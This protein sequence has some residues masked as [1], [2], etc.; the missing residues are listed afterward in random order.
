VFTA[1][2]GLSTYMKQTRFFLKGLIKRRRL[3]S[4]PKQMTVLFRTRMQGAQHGGDSERH[5]SRELSVTEIL[6]S[7]A[8]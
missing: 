3:Q 5:K 4:L 2:Y 8:S 6:R 1:R 7:S